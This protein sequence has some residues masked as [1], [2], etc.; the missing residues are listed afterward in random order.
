MARRVLDH[1][2]IENMAGITDPPS[3]D[4]R[5]CVMGGTAYA[6]GARRCESQS[7]FADGLEAA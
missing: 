5:D 1:L 6:E 7:K 3:N 4:R 2:P